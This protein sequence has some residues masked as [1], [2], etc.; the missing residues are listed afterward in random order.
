[1]FTLACGTSIIITNMTQKN[2]NPSPGNDKNSAAFILATICAFPF[3][4][5]MM[6]AFA[7]H[8]KF[9]Q[10]L[11]LSVFFLPVFL[12]ATVCEPIFFLAWIKSPHW[13]RPFLILYL[14]AVAT[15]WK[16][17]VMSGPW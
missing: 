12:V 10:S 17:V 4:W 2:G 5:V 3:V 16:A 8:P 13:C 1:V 6:D 14:L 9:I 15:Y 11:V 7:S